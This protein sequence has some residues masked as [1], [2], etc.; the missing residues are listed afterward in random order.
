MNDLL[1]IVIIA[2]LEGFIFK[3]LR[4][5]N[6]NQPLRPMPKIAFG[7][8]SATLAFAMAGILQVCFCH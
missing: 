4:A 6:H 8:F 3:K 1:D 7:L 5:F 2:V